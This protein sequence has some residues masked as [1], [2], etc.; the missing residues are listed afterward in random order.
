VRWRRPRFA[1]VLT[2]VVALAALAV[3]LLG[4]GSPKASHNGT[5]PVKSLPSG[6]M[7][8]CLTT[9]A[10]AQAILRGTVSATATATAP[11]RV[12]QKVRGSRSVV[13]V[14]RAASFTASVGATRVVGV[15][16]VS[17][18]S[19]Q[20]CAT[21]ASLPAARGLAIRHAYAIALANAHRQ[22]RA[23]ARQSLHRLET[24]V[25]PSLLAQAQSAAQ[26]RSRAQA[27]AARP[28]L[29]IV[30]HRQAVRLANGGRH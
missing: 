28:A 16:Q 4:G 6:R 8:A 13:T 26:Q 1:L 11:L 10:Q 20:A 3:V 9:R 22:A 30:A 19:G 29:T 7:H 18:G 2:A 15:K 21:A 12:V 27:T 14:T 5:G 23:R 24:Q 17:V 25:Y